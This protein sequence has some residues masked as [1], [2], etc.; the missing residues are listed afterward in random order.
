V[1]T[2]TGRIRHEYLTDDQNS[3][4]VATLA[5]GSEKSTVRRTRVPPDGRKERAASAG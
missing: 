3:L 5:H 2:D 4:A 1:L